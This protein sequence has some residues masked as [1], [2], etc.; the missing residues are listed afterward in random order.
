MERVL[1]FIRE[2]IR[3]LLGLAVVIFAV[4]LLATYII[5]NNNKDTPS[6]C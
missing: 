2:N 4:I 3:L 5:S 6:G 1:F